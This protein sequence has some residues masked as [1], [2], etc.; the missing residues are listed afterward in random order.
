MASPSTSGRPSAAAATIG[1]VEFTPPTSAHAMWVI[2]PSRNGSS[3]R[4]G[5]TTSSSEGS[6][7]TMTV[8]APIIATM[9][10]RA[11]AGTSSTLT[12]ST[13]P[14]MLRA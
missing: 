12:T 13:A 11:L 2:G 1:M 10:T 7:S 14:C 4:T 9:T 5:V 3:A 8:G 6:F